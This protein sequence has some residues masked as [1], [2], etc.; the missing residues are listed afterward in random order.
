MTA[1]R[2]F[3]KIWLPRGSTLCPPLIRSSL[4]TAPMSLEATNEKLQAKVNALLLQVQ[5]LEMEAS[6]SSKQS[7]AP[8]REKITQMSSEVVDTNPYSRL[9]ALQR[10]GIVENYENIR[11]FTVMIVGIGGIGSVAAEMLTRCGVGKLIMFDY[12]KVEIANMNRL[13]FQPYQAGM[14]KTD[15]AKQTLETINP[16]VVFDAYCYDITSSRNFDHFQNLIKNGGLGGNKSVDLVLSCVDNYAARITINTACN[17]LDQVWME[18]GVSEDAVSGHIQ[19][20]LPGRTACFQCVPPLI[21]AQ[22]IDESTL[23]REGVC[24]ASLPTTMGIVAGLLVQNVLKYLLEFGQVSYYLGYNALNNY[25]P[26]EIVRPNVECVSRQCRS[27][28]KKWEGKWQPAV[29]VSPA[30]RARHE[31]PVDHGDNEWGISTDS[32]GEDEEANE[33]KQ[34][35]EERGGGMEDD[36]INA[37][38][39]SSTAPV[40]AATSVPT[41]PPVEQEDEASLEDLM[42]ALNGL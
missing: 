39:G 31:E 1:E 23:K 27:V 19:T 24:A 8:K 17:E 30:E 14:T 28:C 2:I 35:Q 3:F 37:L 12:D 4:L 40:A 11:D 38:N 26:S 41:P 42:N 13:F 5:K 32:D 22:G 16:D 6:G 34:Q 20:M 21:I 15:A 18:S 33:K 9:M 29:W 7:T 10:M 25:F 36:L